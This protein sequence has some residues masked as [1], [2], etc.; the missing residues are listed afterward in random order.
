[1]S[2]S[3]RACLQAL[4]RF[5]E[6]VALQTAGG[7]VGKGHFSPA[8]CQCAMQIVG[9]KGR[10]V[11]DAKAALYFRMRYRTIRQ[12]LEQPHDWV[13]DFGGDWYVAAPRTNACR[14]NHLRGGFGRATAVQNSL[15]LW[16]S[17]SS[18]CGQACSARWMPLPNP[19]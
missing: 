16:W 1:M 14:C 8:C 10:A 18:I 4:A 7:F 5:G 11:L 2:N 15:P 13:G 3:T 9:A 6:P 17:C 19:R 12:N